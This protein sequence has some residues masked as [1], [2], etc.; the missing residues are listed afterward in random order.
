M[1]SF[2]IFL[3]IT[4]LFFLLL[5]SKSLLKLKVCVICL[6][7]SI[8][9][10]AA[11]TLYKLHYFDNPILLALFMG[12]SITGIY[13]LLEKKLHEKYHIFRLPALLSLSLG[14][15]AL[16]S[17]S[18]DISAILYLVLGLWLLFF[19]LFT[20]RKNPKLRTAVDKIIACCK[21]W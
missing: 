21:D 11:L 15:Y 9:W 13:Y 1:T 2:Y 10:L 12:Q 16:L 8:T 14:F 4:V 18:P 3:T 7:V 5:I 17:P 19:G 6:S 20:Y